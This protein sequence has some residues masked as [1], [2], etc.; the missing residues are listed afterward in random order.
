MSFYEQDDGGLELWEDVQGS[1]SSMSRPPKALGCT[2]ATLNA[3]SAWL[4]P[5]SVRRV[6]RCV[7]NCI[8]Q[9]TMT[10]VKRLMPS[11]QGDKRD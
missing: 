2:K 3:S 5:Q 4:K 11:E 6:R 10:V 7:V 1:T 9:V 8:Y